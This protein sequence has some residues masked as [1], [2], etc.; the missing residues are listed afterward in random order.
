ME[1]LSD[2]EVTTGLYP[3]VYPAIVCHGFAGPKQAVKPEIREYNFERG[4]ANA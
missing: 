1:N 4:I 2:Y 3:G